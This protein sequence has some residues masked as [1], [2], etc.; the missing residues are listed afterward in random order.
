MPPALA[1]IPHGLAH[2]IHP[3]RVD[4][5]S[6]LA[7]VA[8]A[9]ALGWAASV[10]A[11]E[12]SDGEP[13]AEE[14]APPP[15]P[16]VIP[17]RLEEVLVVPYPEDG[18]RGDGTVEV[19]VKLAIDE[20]GRYVAAEIELSAGEPFDSM[21]LNTV[22]HASFSPAYVDDVPT[23]VT[24][25][26]PVRFV[27][28]PSRPPAPD[29]GVLVG[30]VREAGTRK[31]LPGI[32]LSL[33]PAE[34]AE[35]PA[36]DPP[37]P[38]LTDREGGFRFVDVPVGRWTVT[39]SGPG[40][41]TARF[42]E[43]V[44]DDLLRQVVYKVMPSHSESRTVVRARRGPPSSA[45]RIVEGEW[46][47]DSAG[48]SGGFL[49]IL[50]SEAPVAPTPVLPMGLMPG[51]PMIRGMEGGDS[52]V[53]VDG[54]E[55]PLLYHFGL[56]TTV[57]AGDL[58]DHVRLD[59]S[60][61]GVEY[62]DH[63]GGL[64]DVT[65]RPPRTDRFG[66]IVDISPIDAT[67]ILETPFGKPVSGFASV[68]R[69]Y[70][71]LYLGKLLPDDMPAQV[72]A[73]PVY[74]DVTGMVNIEPGRGHRIAAKVIASSD[75]MSMSQSDGDEVSVT[76]ALESGF[77]LI[78][79][80]WQS[81]P[82]QPVEGGLSVAYEAVKSSYSAFPDLYLDAREKRLDVR[83]T[84]AFALSPRTR[85]ETGVD[86]R[87][88]IIEYEENFFALPREDEPGLINPYATSPDTERHRAPMNELGVFASLPLRPSAAVKVTP[89]VRMSW[90]NPDDEG[91]A[92]AVDVPATRTTFDPR[93]WTS[94]R[95]T[96]KWRVQG[97]L[98]MYHQVPSLEDLV[99]AGDSVL[100]PEAALRGTGG[101]TWS[102]IPAVD[103]GLD[104][105]MAGLWDLV[106]AHSGLYDEALMGSL[107]EPQSEGVQLLTNEGIGFSTGAEVTLRWHPN[108]NVDVLAAYTLSR[109][110]RRD[111]EDD[112]WRLFQYDRP[113]QLTVAGQVR[114]PHEWSFGLRF[115]LASGAPDT[116][117]WDVVYLA[118]L[119]GYVPRWGIPYSERLGAFHQLDWRVQKVF[120][121]RSFVVAVYLDVENTYFA[122][123]DDVLIYNRDFS[124]RL[125][126]AMIP[127][128]RLGLR[129]EF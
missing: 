106:V 51:A 123:R 116:P 85:L 121:A 78:H 13:V 8:I 42:D 108:E 117:I 50:E 43:P 75:K 14:E 91:L 93:V 125:T 61:S 16:V 33:S 56:L 72:T 77:T 41:R 23:A 109:S 59:P 62:G 86:Y 47:R 89:G 18:P 19:R 54:V 32:Q 67:V 12:A 27:L 68:R 65:L 98:G 122:Q 25:V 58:I 129:T 21:A 60:G 10:P 53:L 99:Q 17:P 83:G 26:V 52:V 82:A 37:D 102:P 48:S 127:L 15:P 114:L 45:E 20:A 97:A 9:L 79:G 118:D 3:P 31:L 101:V 63:I 76:A 120:R 73:M 94:L 36:G 81:P 128:F 29:T 110:M 1:P 84:L 40:V 30:K 124:E 46:I 96:P 126:F 80:L 39:V 57:V 6:P 34:D 88:R 66:G 35:P 2:V 87:H 22:R 107:A 111:S 38:V 105:Y 92:H 7:V 112:P 24:I 74:A 113:H 44:E 71:D 5:L 11:Q 28:P 70:V 95:V 103:L 119:G 100:R 55:T 4:L 104:V 64:V 49:R 115:R 69:S 90:W